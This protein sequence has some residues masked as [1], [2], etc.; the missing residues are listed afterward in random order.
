MD[1]WGERDAGSSREAEG[2]GKRKAVM[3]IQG[4]EE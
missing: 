4:Q 2:G 1:D 3:L